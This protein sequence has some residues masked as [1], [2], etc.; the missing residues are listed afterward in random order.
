VILS[1]CLDFL[2][3][4][5]CLL[6]NRLVV[7]LGSMHPEVVVFVEEG[8]VVFVEEGV[9]VFVAFGVL[10]FQ[11]VVAFV[12]SVVEMLVVV[13]GEVLQIWVAEVEEEVV[14]DF[15]RPAFLRVLMLER[16]EIRHFLLL[17]D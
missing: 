7:F 2:V 10:A 9:V 3:A 1:R 12:A 5:S 16:E 4:R 8:V 11:V 13:L 17:P 15:L 14:K 6:L